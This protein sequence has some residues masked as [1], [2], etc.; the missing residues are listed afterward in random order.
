MNRDRVMLELILLPVGIILK[1]SV[2][3]AKALDAPAQTL[4]P[5]QYMQRINSSLSLIDL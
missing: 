1:I 3:T 2:V 4:S 5:G